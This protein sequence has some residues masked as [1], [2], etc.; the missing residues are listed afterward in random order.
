MVGDKVINYKKGCYD[1]MIVTILYA[2]RRSKSDHQ[3]QD[4]RP[5]NKIVAEHFQ[6]PRTQS[7]F[8]GY[9]LKIV[10]F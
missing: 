8:N 3:E 9:L 6:S 7:L 10:S 1:V 4:G 2:D 5:L